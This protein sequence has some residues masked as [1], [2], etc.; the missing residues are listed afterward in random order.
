[1]AKRVQVMA[2]DQSH[3]CSMTELGERFGIRRNTDD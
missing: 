1:M 2:A 3:V